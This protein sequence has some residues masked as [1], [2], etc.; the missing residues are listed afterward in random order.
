MGERE[1]TSPARLR[2]VC[3]WCAF[4]AG[5]YVSSLAAVGS[6][7][8][9]VGAC[10]ASLAAMFARGWWC[11]GALIAGLTLFGAG[12]GAL[13]LEETGSGSLLRRVEGLAD[14]APVRLAG[15]VATPVSAMDGR[16]N[17]LLPGR[18]GPVG[19]RFELWVY[20]AGDD[21][22]EGPVH[23]CVVVWCEERPVVEAGA[24]VVVSG[25]YRSVAGGMNPG[26]SDRRWWLRARGVAGVVEVPRASLIEA[27]HSYAG[28][29][30]RVASWWDGWRGVLRERAERSVDRAARGLDSSGRALVHMLLLGRPPDGGLEPGSRLR[31]SFTR[32]GLAHVLALS[33]FH[34]VV[35]VALLLK[36][37]RAWGDAGRWEGAGVAGLVALYLVLVPASAPIVRAGVLALV[38]VVSEAL[39]RKYDRLALL[40]WVALGLA[41]WRPAELWSLGY[42]LSCGLTAVLMGM[43]ERVHGRIFPAPVRTGMPT[44]LRFLDPSATR[45]VAGWFGGLFSTT[46]LCWAASM[47]LVLWR[48]GLLTPLAVPAGMVVVPLAVLL[49]GTGFASLLA[50]LMWPGLAGVLSWPLEWSARACVGVVGWLERIPGSAVELPAVSLAWSAAATGV[51][52]WWLGWARGRA[53]RGV[54]LVGLLGAWAGAEWRW[55]WRPGPDVALRI[56]TLAVGD[57]SAHL[58]RSGGESLLWDCGSPSPSAGRRIVRRALRALGETR[59][60]TLVLTHPDVDHYSAVGEAVG[61]LG[62]RRALVSERFAEQARERPSGPASAALEVLRG[63]GVEVVVLSAGDRFVVGEAVFEVLSP[64]PGADWREDN[65]HSLVA[66]AEVEGRGVLLTGDA[67]GKAIEFIRL[68]HPDLRADVAEAPHHGSASCAA[69]VEWLTALGPS[70]VMQSTG[71]GRVDEPG[72]AELRRRSAW[73]VTARDGAAWVE[74]RRGG[75]LAWGSFR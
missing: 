13:R 54:L 27:D 38:L 29:R 35:L 3:A 63:L 69:T 43:G 32:L 16:V 46:L 45:R 61:V 12:W 28:L 64:P 44:D 75:V 18:A 24:R 30:V 23:G 37:V 40:G 34:L 31:D 66:W 6:A 26:E 2:A 72:W 60:P 21:G 10:V 53:W 42:Q 33:G 5:V 52:V 67:Q 7:W 22:R 57:G 4:A 56:D 71:P 14:G 15:V 47:P 65:E 8:W 50:G 73:L 55:A 59:V 41:A 25:R 74:V 39:G 49:L 1:P 68:H 19:G 48:T 58:V 51:A 17:P 70:V 11:R 62:V 36:F 9:F 20:G